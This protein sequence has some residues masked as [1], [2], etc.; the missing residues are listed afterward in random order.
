MTEHQLRLAEM[1]AQQDVLKQHWLLPPWRIEEQRR[2]DGIE[3]RALLIERGVLR[4]FRHRKL[5][6]ADTYRLAATAQVPGVDLE[7]NQPR[8]NTKRRPAG[9][10]T[11]SRAAASARGVS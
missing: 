2:R 3:V 4:A 10:E 9:Y 5:L 1:R 6:D 7:V 11:K 8:A